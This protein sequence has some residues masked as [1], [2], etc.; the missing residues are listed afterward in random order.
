MSRSPLCHSTVKILGWLIPIPLLL[1]VGAG[2]AGV[3][4][5]APTP[6]RPPA[7][8]PFFAAQGGGEPR[9]SGYWLLWNGCAP[10][11]RAETAAANG[12]REAGW[13]IMDD[14]LAD[15]GLLLGERAV[16]TCE[17][18]VRLLQGASGPADDVASLLAAQLLAAQLNLAVGAEYCPAVEAAVTRAQLLLVGAGFDGA[19]TGLGPGADAEESELALSLTEQL[20][21]YNAGALCR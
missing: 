6:T 14:L 3:P 9:G 11:N 18:G 12:G 20:A 7:V 21:Q 8:D 19:G 2:C 17:D 16:A 13:I 15:P 10:G 4:A 5:A 1:L